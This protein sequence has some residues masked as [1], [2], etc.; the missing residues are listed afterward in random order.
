MDRTSR[1]F[2][3]GILAT[4][5]VTLGFL[6]WANAQEGKVVVKLRGFAKAVTQGKGTAEF[7]AG[8]DGRSIDYKVSVQKINDVTA[9][10]I[11]MVGDLGYPRDIVVR[12]YPAKAQTASRHQGSFTGTL[13][14]GNITGDELVGPLKR[15]KLM[16]LLKMLKQ[17]R[18]G[19]MVDTKKNPD[20]ELWGANY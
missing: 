11:R 20:G 9:A 12:L 6:R 4:V 8:K 15:E 1:A 16:D 17:G 3:V 19:V 7:K 18:A 14:E 5:L 10:Q 2:L 13:A